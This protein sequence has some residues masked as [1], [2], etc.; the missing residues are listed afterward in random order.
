VVSSFFTFSELPAYYDDKLLLKVV[1]EHTAAAV[2][3]RLR[4]R[5]DVFAALQDEGT[6]LSVIPIRVEAERAQYVSIAVGG[7]VLSGGD[8]PS[9]E[10]DVS[11]IELKPGALTKVLRQLKTEESVEYVERIPIRYLCATAMAI[12]P[13]QGAL[14]NLKRIRWQESRALNIR[15]PKDI[16]V[17]ILDT[18]VEKEHPD[19]AGRVVS[20]DYTHPLPNVMGEKDLHGHGTHVAGIVGAVTNNGFG[21]CGICECKLKIWK[22]FRDEPQFMLG[23]N[24]FS[25]VVDPVAYLLALKACAEDSVDVVNLSIG[26]PG[27]PSVEEERAFKGLME[28]GVIVIAA[29]GNERMFGSPISYPAAIPGV[30]AVGATNLNDKVTAFSSEGDHICLCAPGQAIWSTLPRYPGQLGF[31]PKHAKRKK[32]SSTAKPEPDLTKPITRETDYD[33]WNGTS[34]AAPHVTGAA[35]LLLANRGK[36]TP[37]RVRDALEK[38]ADKVQGMGSP[39]GRDRNYGAGRLNLLKLLE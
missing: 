10:T 29:M 32:G 37:T 25:Y 3:P 9:P 36:D 34:M 31:L 23:Q 5:R 21:I 1:R 28:K 30:V 6:I 14:W 27:K 2:S 22:I 18:G 7:G 39:Q 11:V 16:T 35:A 24:M 33:A 12:P 8:E 38:C 26:G 20:Y 19:L 15:Q 4:P 13:Q 17:A